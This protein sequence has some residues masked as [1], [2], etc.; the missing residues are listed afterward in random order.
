MKDAASQSRGE[1][2]RGIRLKHECMEQRVWI[3]RARCALRG[4]LFLDSVSQAFAKMT[5]EE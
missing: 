4:V 1:R 3:K 2:A 5:N